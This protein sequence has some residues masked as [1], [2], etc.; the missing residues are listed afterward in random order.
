MA[1]PEDLPPELWK[2]I[3]AYLD[4]VPQGLDGQSGLPEAA[5]DVTLKNLSLVS[6]HLRLNSLAL[7]FK[8]MQLELYYSERQ[9]KD[10]QE[11]TLT[12]CLN[13]IEQTGLRS[14][15]SRISFR[16]ILDQKYIGA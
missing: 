15:I 3:L 7:L 4:K 14:H 8:Y 9:I 16:A 11:A 12:N 6:K 13:F 2:D 1:G 5:S 10:G